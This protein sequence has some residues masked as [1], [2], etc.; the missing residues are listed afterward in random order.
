M[1][2]FWFRFVVGAQSINQ[3]FFSKVGFA[4]FTIPTLIRFFINVTVIEKS[5]KKSFDPLFVALLGGLNKIVIRNF[6]F[7]PDRFK[8]LAHLITIDFGFQTRLSGGLFDIYT[9]LIISHQEM[10]FEALHPFGRSEEHT[11]ELQ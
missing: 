8:F 2:P 7:F 9:M 3:I 11:S 6:Q 4:R 5:L 10:N 1:E